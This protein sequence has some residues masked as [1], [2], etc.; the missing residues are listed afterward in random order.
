MAARIYSYE[1]AYRMQTEA[2]RSSI[3]KRKLRDQGALRPQHRVARRTSGES[4]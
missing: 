2:S 4:A 1:L 3:W